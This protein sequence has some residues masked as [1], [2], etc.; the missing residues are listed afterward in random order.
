VVWTGRA[1]DRW[2]SGTQDRV[3]GFGY[4]RGVAHEDGLVRTWR[5]GRPCP[6]AD[7]LGP[8]RRGAGDPTYHRDGAGDHWLGLRT[9]AG[10]ATLLLRS[11][12]GAGEVRG[13]AWGPGASWALES[14]PGLLGDDDDLTGFVAHHPLVQEA[15]RRIPDPRIGRTQ[16]VLEALV[17]AVIEQKV[18][19]QEAF[20][21]FRRLV[22]RFGEPAPGPGGARRLWIQPDAA[23][24]RRVPSWEWL[25]MPVDPARSRPILTAARVAGSLERLVGLSGEEADRRLRSLPGI[26]V[27][28]SAEVRQ[29]ALGDPD[30]VSFGDYHL[31]K[32]VG[33]ALFGHDIDDAT[34]EE[35]LEPYRPHRGR[36]A[37]LI[38]RAGRSRPRRG[39][40]MAPRTHLPSRGSPR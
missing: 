19:G 4:R 38:L 29:R 39:P 9:P 17:P 18:T 10:P 24:L 31:A 3:G 30:A 26:G 15:L 6:V 7:L 11:S 40:R 14:V 35:V 33:W 16:R 13:E 1:G 34:L 25:R 2:R 22:H 28:T 8:L 21:G 32:Q 27:W 5:P 23:T 12:P 37:M 36:A 20:A